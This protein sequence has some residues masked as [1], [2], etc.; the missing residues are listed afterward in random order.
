MASPWRAPRSEDAI[1]RTHC[2]T[3]QRHQIR[4]GSV[5][6]V[7]CSLNVSTLAYIEIQ[8]VSQRKRT[9]KPRDWKVAR[10][11]EIYER[12]GD[13]CRYCSM[14]L[15]ALENVQRIRLPEDGTFPMD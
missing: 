6:C 9:T 7:R 13:E 15:M 4:V 3:G 14:Q 5:V 10:I 8:R 1:L 11:T 12:D 2:W